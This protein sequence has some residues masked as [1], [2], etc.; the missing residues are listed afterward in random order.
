MPPASSSLPWG[1]PFFSMFACASLPFPPSPQAWLWD[2]MAASM[3]AGPCTSLS[4]DQ[5]WSRAMEPQE[6]VWPFI[7]IL[8]SPFLRSSPS[9]CCWP[10]IGI[11]ASLEAWCYSQYSC[12][13]ARVVCFFSTSSDFFSLA[14]CF[15][16][17]VAAS[18]LEEKIQEANAVPAVWTETPW[19]QRGFT[20]GAFLIHFYPVGLFSSLGVWFGAICGRRKTP[21]GSVIPTICK[22]VLAF[23]GNN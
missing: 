5:P 6:A 12:Y 19:T 8:M 10:G 13:H 18:R 2:P 9:T 3:M 21:V 14:G 20:P 17:L 4:R 23:S 1:H 16:K 7:T 22:M 11:G 15:N